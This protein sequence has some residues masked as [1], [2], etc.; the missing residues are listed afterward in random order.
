[1]EYTFSNRS[2][3]QLNGVD[4]RLSELMKRAIKVS[5]IDFGIP[6]LGGLRTA[7]E[8]KR[9]FDKGVSNCDGYKVK[10]FHQTGK[11]IDVYAFVNNKASWDKQH[12]SLI[13]G[14]VLSEAARLQ[15]GVKWGGT[16]D[17]K[18]FNGWD[19]PHFQLID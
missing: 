12:L 19:M 3:M 16:F 9:L 1:M 2:L 7:E 15:I 10:S 4:A 8:Q 5:P 13:A 6:T 14:V 11:A 18:H 17:S